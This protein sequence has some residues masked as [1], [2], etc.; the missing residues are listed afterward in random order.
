MIFHIKLYKLGGLKG[1]PREM[2]QNECNEK[3]K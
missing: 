3:I 2:E 1:P